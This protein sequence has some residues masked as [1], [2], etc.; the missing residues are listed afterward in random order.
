MNLVNNLIEWTKTTFSPLGPLGLF[1]LAFMESSFFPVPPDLLLIVLCLNKPESSLLYALICTVGSVIGALLGYLI[2]YLGEI[3]ILRKL[4]SEKKIKKVH[5]LFNKYEAWAI[6]IAGFTPIPYK[7]FT[8]AGGVFYI[9]LKKFVLA[10]IASRGLR[11]FIEA[12]LLMLFGKIV[13]SFINDYFDV[14]S[15]AGVAIAVLIFIWY[16]RR[17][18][19][20]RK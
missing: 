1:I 20:R 4:F 19:K 6:F 15:L 17:K 14:L 5:N 9:D 2:G 3:A 13:V 10:S 16:K 11:F 8:I 12:I 7:I 18:K